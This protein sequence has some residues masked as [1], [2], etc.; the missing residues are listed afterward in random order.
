M[1]KQM[2]NVI[3]EFDP[4]NDMNIKDE[5]LKKNVEMLLKLEERYK[6]HAIRSNPKFQ[7]IYDDYRQ[8]IKLDAEYKQAKLDFKKAKNLLQEEELLCRKR[9]L[10]RL[11]YCDEN[12]IITVKVNFFVLK[13]NKNTKPF[14]II[15]IIINFFIY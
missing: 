7:Q 9:V 13:F 10:R 1:L 11:Q 6:T 3:P 5:T 14:L 2:N 4:I 15:I 12:E 8:K